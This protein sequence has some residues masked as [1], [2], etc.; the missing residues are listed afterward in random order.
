[1]DLFIGQNVVMHEVS[2][3]FKDY[4]HNLIVCRY[5]SMLLSYPIIRANS[6]PKQLVVEPLPDVMLQN[7]GEITLNNPEAL[8]CDSYKSFL[9]YY[10]VYYTSAANGF[11]KF[12]DYSTAADRK[13]AFAKAHLLGQV[14]DI[15]LAQLC[16][17]E[18]DHVSPFPPHPLPHPIP[19][20]CL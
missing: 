13:L 18:K 12:N 8:I 9:Y 11:K 16:V 4:L 15:W 3:A 14:F 17:D 10:V 2:P 19:S 6:D 5:W 7:I 20:D 1:M